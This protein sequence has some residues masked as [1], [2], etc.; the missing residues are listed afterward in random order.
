MSD[1][2]TIVTVD[3]VQKY[4]EVARVLR[5]QGSINRS[6]IIYS[7]SYSNSIDGTITHRGGSSDLGLSRDN[8]DNIRE[9][10][11]SLGFIDKRKGEGF[12]DYSRYGYAENTI[13]VSKMSNDRGYGVFILGNGVTGNASKTITPGVHQAIKILIE[14][15]VIEA[16]GRNFEVPYWHCSDIYKLDEVQKNNMRFDWGRKTY[17]DKV[18]AIQLVLN[19]YGFSIPMGSKDN[20]S[21]KKTELALNAIEKYLNISGNIKDFNYYFN[22]YNNMPFAGFIPNNYSAL[23]KAINSINS[24]NLPSYVEH[25]R[26]LPI[27]PKPSETKATSVILRGDGSTDIIYHPVVKPTKKD[28]KKEIDKSEIDLSKQRIDEAEA[29][30]FK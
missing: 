21:V 27:K 3:D 9:I 4:S 15:S 18:K 26:P 12:N 24:G 30:L 19:M 1:E 28:I 10:S 23:Q 14:H 20:L 22:L 5:L 8:S 16:F 7:K 17:K 11:L 2:G 25:P 6:D 13:R 29:E